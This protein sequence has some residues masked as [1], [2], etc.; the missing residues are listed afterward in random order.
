MLSLWGIIAQ[1][2]FRKELDIIIVYRDAKKTAM[3]K[4]SIT[5]HLQPFILRNPLKWNLKFSI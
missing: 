2:D 4:S 3:C 5:S 1:Q